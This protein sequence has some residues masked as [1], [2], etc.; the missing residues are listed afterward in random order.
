MRPASQAPRGRGD[1]S[2][3]PS[4]DPEVQAA[5]VRGE[6]LFDRG[7][8]GEAHSCFAA[9]HRRRSSDLRCRS[10]YGLTLILVEHNNNL[11]VRYCEEAV[12]ASGGDRAE[13]WLNLARAFKALGYRERAV[14]ALNRGLAL[15]PAHVGLR[16]EME[17]LGLRV[18]PVLG[19]LG[20]SNPLNRLL[21]HWRQR[22][23]GS[24][25]GAR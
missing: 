3:Q 7:L 25:K 17:A 15:D 1:P 20:R 12:R 14:R 2:P 19:F 24:R 23:R 18:A 5:L 16:L 9:A 13:G 10:W 11:G 22:L 21:G 4:A 6:E 8:L